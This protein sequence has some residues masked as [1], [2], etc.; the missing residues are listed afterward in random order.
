MLEAFE[1]EGKKGWGVVLRVPLLYGE[2][3][4]EESAVNVLMDVVL[5]QQDVR[6]GDGKGRKKVDAWALRYPTN[7]EDVGRICQ[8]EL[9][10]ILLQTDLC[11]AQLLTW[12]RYRHCNSLPLHSHRI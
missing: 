10:Y 3:E 11:T 4:R 7:T 8:G 6:E 5:E 1:K 12:A 9:S 2:G